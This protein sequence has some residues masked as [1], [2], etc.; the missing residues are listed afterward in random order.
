MKSLFPK[1][2]AYQGPRE[3]MQ[4]GYYEFEH[5]YNKPIKGANIKCDKLKIIR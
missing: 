2:R 4:R 1:R 5:A 3:G